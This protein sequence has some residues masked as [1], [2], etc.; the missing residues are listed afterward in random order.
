VIAAQRRVMAEGLSGRGRL[1]GRRH[2]LEGVKD[3]FRYRRITVRCSALGTFMGI[4]PGPGVS[5]GQW[6]MEHQAELTA[7]SEQRGTRSS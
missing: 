2:R 7:T 6:V 4:I 3:T 5:V 1:D